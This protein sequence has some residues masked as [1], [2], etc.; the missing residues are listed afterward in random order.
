MNEHTKSRVKQKTILECFTCGLE[1][2][3]CPDCGN[4]FDVN[5]II[6]CM[7]DSSHKCDD[8]FETFIE[9]KDDELRRKHES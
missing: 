6:F 4:Y 9:E 3:Q 1:V 7:I 2:Y 5:H 8:C